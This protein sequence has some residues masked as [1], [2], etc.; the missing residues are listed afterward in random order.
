MSK[1]L[2]QHDDFWDFR[3][4]FVSHF[5]AYRVSTNGNNNSDSYSGDICAILG[6]DKAYMKT[7]CTVRNPLWVLSLALPILFHASV[8]IKTT[9]LF[10]VAV[11][12]LMILVHCISY[13]IE[14]MVVS[15]VR[16]SIVLLVAAIIITVAELLLQFNG[17]L[18]AENTLFIF[19]SF[20]VSGLVIWPTIV[21]VAKETF[22]VRMKR[23]LVLSASFCIGLSLFA[24]IRIVIGSIEFPFMYTVTAGFWLFAL[25]RIVMAQCYR[26]IGKRP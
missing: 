22:R 7:I 15:W 18:K 3:R 25:C 11:P 21:S 23:V 24:G 17:L 12:I 4:W 19:R 9:V 10:A 13:V 8:E 26:I 16:V 20:V 2:Q 6:L 14:M 5:P 1:T